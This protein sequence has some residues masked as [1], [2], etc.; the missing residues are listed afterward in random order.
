MTA[1]DF[2]CADR[3]HIL[4]FRDRDKACRPP[5]IPCPDTSCWQ[6]YLHTRCGGSHRRRLRRPRS[7]ERTADNALQAL[8]RPAPLPRC[9]RER[10]A[11]FLH[12]D[13]NTHILLQKCADVPH[14]SVH[15]D[16]GYNHSNNIG[17]A[18]PMARYVHSLGRDKQNP[19][20]SLQSGKHPPP[21]KKRHTLLLPRMFEWNSASKPVYSNLFYC[22]YIP[23]LQ[24]R[25]GQTKRHRERPSGS[26][27]CLAPARQGEVL[28][29]SAV[30]LSSFPL[31]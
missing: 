30:W 27:W 16:S 31:L 28:S 22:K 15:I 23:C 2:R 29:K 12:E 8:P 20:P 3:R 7:H 25:T 13:E 18:H 1:P 17:E 24:V 11:L 5:G 6:S 19:S 26:S 9:P 4:P 14:R 10:R 21:P